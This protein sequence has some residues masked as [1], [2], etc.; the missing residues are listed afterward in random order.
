MGPSA[1]IWFLAYLR[2]TLLVL[3]TVEDGPGDAAGVLALEEKR[4][5]LAILETEDLAVATDVQLTLTVSKKTC[6]HFWSRLACTSIPPLVVL[7][8]PS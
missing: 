3:A 8:G 5:G 4:L 7:V 1:D 6:Q 2:D